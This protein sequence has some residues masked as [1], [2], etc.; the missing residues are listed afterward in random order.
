MM[1]SSTTRHK[2]AGSGL[3]LLIFIIVVVVGFVASVSNSNQQR[4]S[5]Q[6]ITAVMG[7]RA[8]MAARSAINVE[9]SRFYQTTTDGSCHTNSVQ[10][11]TF[12]GEGLAQCSAQVECNS[13]GDM[14]DGRTVHQ[15]TSTG[16]CQAGDWTLQRVIE[17]GVKSE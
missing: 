17:V 2:Q 15:L 3:I 16:R 13:V 12:E 6:L 14:D 4:S 8:E 1:R 7:M 10:S 9:L 11:L 5:G